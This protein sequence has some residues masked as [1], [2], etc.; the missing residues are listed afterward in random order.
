[1]PLTSQEFAR[2]SDRAIEIVPGPV[3]LSW[4][5]SGMTSADQ[6]T[7]TGEFACSAQLADN[8]TD[9]KMFAEVL[10]GHRIALTIA[11]LAE[12]FAAVIRSVATETAP[13]HDASDWISG[14][15]TLQEMIDAMAQAAKRIAFACGLEILPP[16]ELE[17]NSPSL[18][19]KRLQEFARARAEERSV[20]QMAHL[21]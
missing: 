17:L 20:E 8:P 19:E 11:D 16:Y 7:L 12:H 21:K 1:M 2:R 13:K 9:R 5:L 18:K 10:I 14:N 4:T 15:G 3:R 6:H